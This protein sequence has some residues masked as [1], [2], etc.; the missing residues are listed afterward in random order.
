MNKIFYLHILPIINKTFL[1][2]TISRF[3]AINETK[4]FLHK[5]IMKYKVSTESGKI[6]DKMLIGP[7][8]SPS[9]GGLVFENRVK[10]N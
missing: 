5:V 2:F 8:T 6:E 7:S 3:F 4:L 10:N 9:Q 1:F